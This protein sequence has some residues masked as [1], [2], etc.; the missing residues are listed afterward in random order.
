VI[1]GVRCDVRVDGICALLGC[2]EA[3]SGNSLLTFRYNI[4]LPPS[5]VKKSKK[6]AQRLFLDFLTFED[7][8]D[9]L[10]RNVGTEILPNAA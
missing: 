9:R 5:V 8:T 7:G 10:S 3:L 6:K 4:A 2:Y 1:S